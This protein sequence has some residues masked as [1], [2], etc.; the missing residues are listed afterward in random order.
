MGGGKE[1]ERR[2]EGGME[3][4]REEEGEGEGGSGERGRKWNVNFWPVYELL[5]VLY[6]AEYTRELGGAYSL[7]EISNFPSAQ[8][9]QHT[10]LSPAFESHFSYLRKDWLVSPQ[11][12]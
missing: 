3:G 11:S 6:E 2:R 10:S 9:N 7:L 1:G 4:G 8:T 5:L 12:P